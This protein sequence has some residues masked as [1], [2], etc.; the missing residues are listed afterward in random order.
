MEGYYQ[1]TGARRGTWHRNQ[2]QNQLGSYLR[3]RWQ[4]ELVI[5]LPPRAFA[6][7]LMPPKCASMCSYS[8]SADERRL[9]KEVPT[10]AHSM[11]GQSQLIRCGPVPRWARLS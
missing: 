2:K 7:V 4:A 5:D 3:S 8:V 11:K 6:F 9:L 1:S 10:S